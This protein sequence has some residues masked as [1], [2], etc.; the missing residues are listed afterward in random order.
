[1]TVFDLY[2]EGL[3][4]TN[5]PLA[6]ERILRH[7]VRNASQ[8]M[9]SQESPKII[10]VKTL[11]FLDR[12]QVEIY[13]SDSGPGILTHLRQQIFRRRLSLK[14]NGSGGL[15]LLLVHFL[16]KTIGGAIR[17]LPFSS[18]A[19]ATFVIRLPL[20]PSAPTTDLETHDESATD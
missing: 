13:I 11:A 12:G 7:L 17:V 15:G 14:P 4:I 18:E 2:C 16:V 19:G 3:E 8:A 9:T 20:Q 10:R 1:M 6:I 5:Y